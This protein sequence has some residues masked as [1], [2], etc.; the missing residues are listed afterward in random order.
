MGY[1]LRVFAVAF[2]AKVKNQRKKTYAQSSQVKRIRSKM[3]EII[4]NTASSKDLSRL[5]KEFTGERLGAVIEKK[6]GT[7][8]PLQ[9]GHTYLRKVKVLK[10]PKFDPY[11]L[12]EI[13]GE[14]AVGTDSGKK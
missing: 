6:C 8:F 9:K 3:S 14:Q 5:V 10:T 12:L 2:T 13:H 11:K 1:T 7:I 4:E